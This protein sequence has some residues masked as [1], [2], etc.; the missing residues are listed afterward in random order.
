MRFWRICRRR[1]AADAAKGEGARLYG[2]RWNSRGVPMVYASTSL[3]LAAVETFVNLE[4]N[5]RP[6]DLISIEGNIPDG[7]EISR[8]DLKTLPANW[9]ETRD[10][11]LRRF[12]DDWIR[13]GQTAALLVP[14]AAIRGEWN[15]LLNPAHGDFSKIRFRKPQPFEFDVRMFR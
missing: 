2:G 11:S 14:S 4:P 10:E 3:A 5:L 13:A 1:Y 12:G 8:V 15:V 6:K 9:H 7:L